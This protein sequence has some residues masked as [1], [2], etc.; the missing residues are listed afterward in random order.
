MN[1][2]WNPHNAARDAVNC[3]QACREDVEALHRDLSMEGLSPSALACGGF[4]HRRGVCTP[5]DENCLMSI[6]AKK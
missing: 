2:G 1:P 3:W 4:W 6:I 5:P